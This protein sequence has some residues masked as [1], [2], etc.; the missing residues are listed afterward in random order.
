MRSLCHE[1]DLPPAKGVEF[2]FGADEFYRAVVEQDAAALGVVV[3]ERKQLR[4]ACWFH[5]AL[6]SNSSTISPGE[7]HLQASFSA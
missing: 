3:V 2:F 4:P 5:P 7:S 6:V 1:A